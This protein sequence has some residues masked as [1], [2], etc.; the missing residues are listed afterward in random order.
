MAKPC[1]R[2]FY[3]SENRN[4]FEQI[5]LSGMCSALVTASGDQSMMHTHLLLLVSGIS[6]ALSKYF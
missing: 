2:W 6:E 1:G 3:S 5:L 4:Y